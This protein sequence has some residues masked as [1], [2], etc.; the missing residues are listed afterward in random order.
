MM[1]IPMKIQLP[2]NKK[3]FRAVKNLEVRQV[4]VAKLPQIFKEDVDHFVPSEYTKFNK[5][6]EKKNAKK[7]K[8][9][10]TTEGDR[11]TS[12]KSGQTQLTGGMTN[13]FTQFTGG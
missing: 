8:L 2:E 13:A 6:Q 4:N 11:P 5:A 1:L 10:Y 7:A 12:A 3:K 9:M